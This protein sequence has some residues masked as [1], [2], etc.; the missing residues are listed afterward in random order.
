MAMSRDHILPAVLRKVSKTFRT[1]YIA[2]VATTAFMITVIL[3]LSLENLVKTASTLKILLFLFV[4]L[5]LMVMRE[6]RIQSYRPKFRA[7]LYP[8]IYSIAVLVYGFLILQMGRVSLI[9]SGVFITC[10]VIWYFAYGR[11]RIKRQAALLHVIERATSRELAGGTLPEELRDIIIERDSIVEDRFDRL[12]KA[13]TILD[14]EGSQDF[15]QFARMVSKKVSADL[16][17]DPK[18][19]EEKLLSR[20]AESSTVIGEGIAIPHIVVEGEHKFSILPARSRDGICFSSENPK[21]HIVFVLAGT[22]DER[23]FHLRALSAIAQIVQRPHF[24][25]RWMHAKGVEELRD[26]ILLGE[27]K[28][29]TPRS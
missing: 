16:S 10:A 15:K 26:V 12:M 27:R 4:N 6:S 28:R 9:V 20:E 25:E 3:F 19:I 1:P 24:F 13:T 22:R 8:W 2:I 23:N 21:I 29:H 17:T 18:A 14:V 7:P 5:S 11:T